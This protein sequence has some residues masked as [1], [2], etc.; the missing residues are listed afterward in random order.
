MSVPRA[1][2]NIRLLFTSLCVSPPTPAPGVVMLVMFVMTLVSVMMVV[3]TLL[4][5]VMFSR[6]DQHCDNHI[7][8]ASQPSEYKNQNQ[9]DNLYK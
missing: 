7:L 8:T 6:H 3:M 1:S 2:L 9:I 4:M 5:P